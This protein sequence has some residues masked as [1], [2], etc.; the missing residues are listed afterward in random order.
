MKKKRAICALAACTLLALGACN[1]E[2][3]RAGS[4]EEIGNET[5][6]AA[7]EGAEGLST[8]T[9][10]LGNAGLQGVFDGNAPYTIFAPTDE[11]FSDLDIPLDDPQG[12]AARVAIMREHIVPGFLTREDIEAAMSS[13][14]GSVEL[15]TMG[16]NT[17]TF[18]SDGDE[19]AI[20]A[21]DGAQAQ[22][23]GIGLSVANGTVFPINGV[24]KSMDQPG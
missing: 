21:S 17:L 5:L 15:Q 19:I 16:S 10:I 24:L 14:G 23:S 22:I 1:S 13:S 18:S 11:A 12:R 4:G 3:E 2:T 7:L 20:T 8:A 9:E 6:A